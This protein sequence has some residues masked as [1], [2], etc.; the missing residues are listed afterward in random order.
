MH[1]TKA[2]P[3][4]HRYDATKHQAVSVSWDFAIDF[5]G[6]A[7]Q[8]SKSTTRAPVGALPTNIN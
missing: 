6:S 3:A 1:R 2:Q 4:T 8:P 5:R 7:I